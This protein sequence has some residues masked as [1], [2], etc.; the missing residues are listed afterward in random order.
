MKLDPAKLPVGYAY[1]TVDGKSAM[2]PVDK[3]SSIGKK[4]QAVARA[5][6]IKAIMDQN[7]SLKTNP[8]LV[9]EMK[10]A[11]G[12]IVRLNRKIGPCVIFV[13]HV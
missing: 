4:N 12:K 9:R 1:V 6:E 13:D 11:M 8:L 5:L 2:A 3:C 10:E 7:P